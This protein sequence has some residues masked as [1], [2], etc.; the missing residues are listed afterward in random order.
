[1]SAVRCGTNAGYVTHIQ[2]RE[3]PC[4]PCGDAHH[5]YQLAYQ[6]ARRMGQGLT[7]VQIPTALLAELYLNST[8]ELQE[9]VEHHFG[10]RV[11]DAMVARHDEVMS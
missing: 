10:V 11:V 8:P 2:K 9:S 1:M 7:R 4:E 5:E 3:S 6:R